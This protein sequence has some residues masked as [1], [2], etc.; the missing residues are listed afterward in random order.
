MKR[1]KKI[2]R[3][4]K[5][6]KEKD[7]NGEKKG[8]IRW[9][10]KCFVLK[11]VRT[12]LLKISDFLGPEWQ[13]NVFH[14]REKF[15]GFGS[16][17]FESGYQVAVS[18]FQVFEKGKNKRQFETFIWGKENKS[19]DKIEYKMSSVPNVVILYI[20]TLNHICQYGA[21]FAE[22]CDPVISLRHPVGCAKTVAP[23]FFPLWLVRKPYQFLIH[24]KNQRISVFTFSFPS[25]LPIDPRVSSNGSLTLVIYRVAVINP[26][27]LVEILA[28]R[29]REKPPTIRVLSSRDL[30]TKRK[31]T[32]S[33]GR[34]NNPPL[35][36]T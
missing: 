8:K 5:R 30:R 26:P 14:F 19:L 4:K 28:P 17:G 20:S 6:K 13:F 36:Q 29:P 7:Q 9:L 2:R 10:A 33:G 34:E 25:V 32:L 23:N 11:Q 16:R 3:R 22:K 1:G 21:C 24:V 15:S 18:S 12:S 31:T 35:S 27:P